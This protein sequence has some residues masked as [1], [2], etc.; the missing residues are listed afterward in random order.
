M[1]KTRKNTRERT[2]STT[3]YTDYTDFLKGFLFLFLF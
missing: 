3:D 1:K 2:F